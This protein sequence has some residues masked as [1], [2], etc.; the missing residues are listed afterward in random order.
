MPDPLSSPQTITEIQALLAR[1]GT[2]PNRRFGQNFLIDGNLMRRIVDEA[3]LDPARDVVLEVGTGTG[4]LTLML[5]DR[6]ARVI[7]VEADK[8]LIP[9]T[10]EVLAG[11]TNVRSLIADVLAGKHVVAPEV[12]QA[13]AEAMAEGIR[14]RAGATY[15]LSITG[16][17]GPTGGTEEKPV[18]LVY[19]GIAD[20]KVVKAFKFQ[21]PGT[22]DL[23]KRRT[24]EA[25]LFL[26]WRML[27]TRII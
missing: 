26:L 23:I 4:S 24:S 12:L 22:R 2:E 1:H 21:M 5:S 20:N 16:V 15:G 19:L 17:A 9:V 14:R 25:A 13:V 10:A 3:E 7:T 27:K 8:K 11:R 6:A 18:G